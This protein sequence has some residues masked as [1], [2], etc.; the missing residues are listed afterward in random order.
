APP[1]PRQESCAFTNNNRFYLLGGDGLNGTNNDPFAY[2]TFPLDL[3]QNIVWTNVTVN[4]TFFSPPASQDIATLSGYLKPCVVTP[5][6][7]LIVGGNDLIGYDIKNDHWLGPLNLTGDVPPILF[8]PCESWG[9]C[10]ERVVQVDDSL[11]IFE[12]FATK[13]APPGTDIYILNLT[14]FS[15]TTSQQQITTANPIPPESDFTSLYYVPARDIP[16]S[17][18]G[19][20]F[21]VGGSLNLVYSVDIWIFN[22]TLLTWFRSPQEMPLGVDNAHLFYF[23]LTTTMFVFPG[24]T[25]IN[26]QATPVSVMQT[27]NLTLTQIKT[28]RFANQNFQPSPRTGANAVQQGNTFVVYGGNNGSANDDKFYIFNM[29][30]PEWTQNALATPSIVAPITYWTPSPTGTSTIT[31][32]TNITSIASI[33]SI[34]SITSTPTGSTMSPYPSNL[35]SIISG[36]VSGFAVL[37][38]AGIF[39]WFCR[40]RQRRV[41]TSKSSMMRNFFNDESSS[42]MRYYKNSSATLLPP[43][44]GP[45]YAAPGAPITNGMGTSLMRKKTGRNAALGTSF[46]RKTTTGRTAA[47]GTSLT[48]KLTGRNAIEDPVDETTYPLRKTSSNT[49]FIIKPYSSSSEFQIVPSPLPD[50]VPG[51][52]VLTEIVR[53][54]ENENESIELVEQ[55]LEKEPETKVWAGFGVEELEMNRAK[56]RQPSIIERHPDIDEDSPRQSPVVQHANYCV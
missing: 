7:T 36:T 3:T 10:S 43:Y 16:L 52:I 6:G 20:I 5:N 14:T 38:A 41:G 24:A 1:G 18:D 12:D 28:S 17:S 11:W 13:G 33:T 27:L 23:P 25:I 32:I 56:K 31:G 35:A 9:A 15:W 46:T 45:D 34:T 47:T 21:M 55:T 42:F 40:R 39:L 51:S 49:S 4:Y 8:Q 29:E 26:N 30:V 22:I 19:V 37:T 44:D 2:T 50:S 48:R 54:K 53:P